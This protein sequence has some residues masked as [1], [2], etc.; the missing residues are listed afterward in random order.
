MGPVV[1]LRRLRPICLDF[2]DL[3]RLEV[4]F[5]LN[6][7]L[8]RIFRRRSGRFVVFGPKIRLLRNQ[9]RLEV[10]LSIWRLGRKLSPDFSPGAPVSGAYSANA[11]M[12][13]AAHGA[14]RALHFWAVTACS[15]RRPI[16][17][18][19]TERIFWS[20]VLVVLPVL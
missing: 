19:E 13:G 1:F 18:L 5:K 14:E 10:H 2:L 12:K 4:T 3:A 16:W 17:P 8:N 7:S 9:R 6:V 15:I 20:A 11:V